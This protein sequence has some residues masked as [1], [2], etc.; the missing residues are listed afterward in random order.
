MIEWFATSESSTRVFW[1]QFL[2]GFLR[3]HTI[4]ALALAEL[5]PNF[6]THAV[7][8][9]RVFNSDATI[10]VF[11]ESRRKS[12]PTVKWQL[13]ATTE[14]CRRLCGAEATGSNRPGIGPA[15]GHQC[16]SYVWRLSG[17]IRSR[18]DTSG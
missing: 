18:S 6:K 7:R 3:L 17:V 1:L 8:N 9:M 5:P 2:V 16:Q 13:S 12:P 10:S 15:Y 4:N 14:V 11:S